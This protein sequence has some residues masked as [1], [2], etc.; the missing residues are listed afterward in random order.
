MDLKDEAKRQIIMGVLFIVLMCF[1][2]WPFLPRT[3]YILRTSQR[4][5]FAVEWLSLI[6]IPFA[7]ITTVVSYQRYQD[8][9]AIFGTSNYLN[10]SLVTNKK[11]A[12]NT[13]E[14]TLLAAIVI[15]PLASLLPNHQLKVIPLFAILFVL[16][17]FLYWVTYRMNPMLRFTGFAIG[18]YPI[19]GILLFDL[20]LM[21]N[22]YWLN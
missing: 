13:F 6:A 12:A 15:F 20:W 18:F 10:K 17:R 5:L 21:V 11:I 1:L 2:L 22:K 4:I 9:K 8:R 3:D 14:Q 16:G 19:I 7:T